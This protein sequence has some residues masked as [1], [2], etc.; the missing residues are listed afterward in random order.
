LHG[1]RGIPLFVSV[2]D[3]ENKFAS[4]LAREEP[5]EKRR[6]G[7]AHVKVASRR[8]SEASANCHF[9]IL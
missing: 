3:T 6:A 5:V 7:A 2:F 8:W 1:R 9:L 4:S